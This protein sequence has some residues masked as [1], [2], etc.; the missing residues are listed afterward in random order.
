MVHEVS[1]LFGLT[2]DQLLSLEGFKE[3]KSRNLIDAIHAAK[4]CECWRF[5][6]ALGIEHIGEVASK[7]LCGAF[8]TAFDRASREE[9]LALEGFGGE[10]VES[11]LEFVRVNG[12]KIETLRS[13]L[14]PVA[15]VKIEAA[16]NPFKGKSVVI[17]GTMSVPRD[18]IKAMLEERGAKI[19]SSV[20]KKTDYVVYGEDAGSKYDK[21]VELGVT[22]LTESEFRSLTSLSD[23]GAAPQGSGVQPKNSLFD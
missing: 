19:A 4:G 23:G 2:M 20:S 1:D 22:L 3:K 8:G 15:P 7:T 21:A 13:I 11:V 17:T 6:N 16:E 14:S 10:M 12:D 9:I 18:H 5:I